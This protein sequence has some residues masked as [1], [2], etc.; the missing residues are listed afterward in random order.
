MNI[1]GQ[2]IRNRRLELKMTQTDL[3]EKLGLKNKCSISDVEN[4]RTDITTERV[5]KFADAL[6][7]SPADLMGWNSNNDLLT[8]FKA[9]SDKDRHIICSI[10]EIPFR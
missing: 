4:G 7:C 5:R 8:A 6:S 10:L 2:N 9:A 1:V 3:A